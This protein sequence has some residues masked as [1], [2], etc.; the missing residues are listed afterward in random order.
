MT[1]APDPF[2]FVLIAG[3]GWIRGFHSINEM[4][5]NR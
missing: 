5:L 4:P 3:G 2:R 1:N